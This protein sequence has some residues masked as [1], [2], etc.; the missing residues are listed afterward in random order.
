MAGLTPPD[1]E[2]VLRTIRLVGSARDPDEFSRLVVRELARL[3]PCDAIA[4]N[5]VDTEAGRTS[6]VAEPSTFFVHPDL[7][8][9]FL[10]LA[11]GHPLI[12]HYMTTADGSAKKISDFWSLEEFHDSAIYKQFY[13]VIGAEY[14]MSVTLPAPRPLVLAIVANR[15]ESDFTERDRTVLNVLRPHLVQAWF[16]AR[17]QHRFRTLLSA[18]SDATAA[19]G[20]EIIILTD[21]PHEVTTGALITL[22]RYFGRPAADGPLPARVA[23][24]IDSQQS[25]WQDVDTPQSLDVL[26]PLWVRSGERQVVLRY[27]PAQ[28]D[29]PGAVLLRVEA[30]ALQQQSL[31][32]LGL[33]QREV[34]IVKYVTFGDTN[35]AIARKLHVSPGTVKK[36]LDNIYAKL[37]VR[38]R[39][40]LT[41]FVLDVVE[42]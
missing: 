23:R 2:S 33:T 32:A 21:P 17:D 34:E 5:E 13:R 15:S 39:G 1:L 19:S 26:R 7:Q 38:S 18:V 16:N 30:T 12:Q 20:A 8:A 35:A 22:Y 31:V 29:H 3:I 4:L 11:D 14:Q 9:R 28:A 27:L 37:G 41:A 10:E 40:R 42:R 36:H 24:W 25:R 6:F